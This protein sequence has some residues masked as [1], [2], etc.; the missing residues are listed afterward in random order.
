MS[1]IKQI[2]VLLSVIMLLGPFVTELQV[3]V[4]CGAY[5]HSK[6]NLDLVCERIMSEIEL[7]L[8]Y[9]VEANVRK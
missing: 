9:K 8:L 7:D 4:S 2:A 6:P 5:A 1:G 3:S